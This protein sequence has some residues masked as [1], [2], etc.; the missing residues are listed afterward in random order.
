LLIIREQDALDYLQAVVFSDPYRAQLHH[1]RAALYQQMGKRDQATEE[2]EAI[3][4]LRKI[5]DGLKL[6][7]HP[8][9]SPV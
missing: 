2:M 3:K 9:S 6:A 5:G 8:A 7:M 4:Q 1:H